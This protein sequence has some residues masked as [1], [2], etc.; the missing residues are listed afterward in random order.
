MDTTNLPVDAVLVAL[1]FAVTQ[2]V[3]PY[4]ELVLKPTDPLHDNTIRSFAVLLALGLR[5]VE[6]GLP[7]DGAGAI[8]LLGYGLGTGLTAVGA[9][10][11]LRGTPV[12]QLR[13]PT[14][15]LVVPP[16]PPT[17]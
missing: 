11:L 1:V 12:A 3:K 7:T 9:Y 5:L 2:L 13:P 14:P 8:A 15:P 16:T 6:F 17:A 4:I 10:G